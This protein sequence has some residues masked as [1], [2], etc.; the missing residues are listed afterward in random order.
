MVVSRWHRDRYTKIWVKDWGRLTFDSRHTAALNRTF[1]DGHSW[2]VSPLIVFL[3]K[4]WCWSS[5]VTKLNNTLNK[6]AS[7]GFK[8]T[9]TPVVWTLTHKLKPDR[10]ESLSQGGW[11]W[12]MWPTATLSPSVPW[13]FLRVPKDSVIEIRLALAAP[14]FSSSSHRLC[15]NSW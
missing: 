13:L 5:T 11:Q 4:G 6:T 3:S 9:G 10:H 8:N 7:T 2:C 14:F 1:S 15:I 12:W